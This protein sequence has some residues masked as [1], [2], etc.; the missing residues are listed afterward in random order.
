MKRRAELV[1]DKRNRQWQMVPHHLLVNGRWTPITRHK[2]SGVSCLKDLSE[3]LAAP[4]QDDAAS[5][6]MN[7]EF[8]F[9]VVRTA[10]E[11]LYLSDVRERKSLD[12][13]KSWHNMYCGLALSNAMI[14]DLGDVPFDELAKHVISGP[15]EASEGIGHCLSCSNVQPETGS[16]WCQW[17]D[18]R[19]WKTEVTLRFSY[20]RDE[21][22]RHCADLAYKYLILCQFFTEQNLPPDA[23][24]AIFFLGE[25]YFLWIQDWLESET[26]IR[27]RNLRD[28]TTGFINLLNLLPI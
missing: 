27:D 4:L 15:Y 8:S 3:F 24:Y 28:D 13:A 9:V 6:V 7:E 22:D 2:T 19:R 5:A 23:L 16:F 20:T 25:R 1:L 11:L 18:R 10:D 12:K 14:A 21:E 26:V 17:D